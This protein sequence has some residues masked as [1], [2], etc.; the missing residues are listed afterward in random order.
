MVHLYASTPMPSAF[1]VGAPRCGT[2]ALCYF[3][4]QHPAIFLPY[5]KEPH[6]F[7]SD[8]TTR[9]GFPNLETYLSLFAEAGTKLC[10]EGSTW[11]L[12]SRCAANE[13]H[14]FDPH[15]KIIIMLRNPSDLIRSWHAHALTVGI[16]DET[17][18]A[19]ALALEP[20][21]RKGSSLPLDSPLEK[22]LY[23]EI[24]AFTE[25]IRRYTKIFRPEQIHVIIYDDFRA[26][27]QKTV[28]DTL[29]FLGVAAD[30]VPKFDKI[31]ASGETKSYLVR[32]LL[33]HQPER[34]RSL[35]RAA[36][37]RKLRTNVKNAVRQMNTEYPLKN[38]V[39]AEV[40]RWLRQHFRAEVQTLSQLLERDL[41][42]WSN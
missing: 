27:N 4:G 40:D 3:L 36:L 9:R 39:D 25:Q 21:R 16:Q 31:N 14:T 35:V 18:L 1:V 8:L 28:A 10:I 24:P 41:S 7:G 6:Y 33:E 20:E 12:Y 26:D 22:L 23:T 15:A 13:I 19:K 29:R 34:V 2:T 17:S 11:Y 32:N 30:F 38:E 42:H 37:P 5:I